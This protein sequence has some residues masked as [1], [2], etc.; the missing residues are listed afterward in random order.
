MGKRLEQLKNFGDQFLMTCVDRDPNFS[1]WQE[2]DL[3]FQGGFKLAFSWFAHMSHSL[4]GEIN[5]HL[6]GR[7]QPNEL[8][9]ENNY[10]NRVGWESTPI[11]SYQ[12]ELFVSC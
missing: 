9:F 3:T 1:F 7:E 11:F 8:I 12:Q 6:K 2:L 5:D 10:C 4:K